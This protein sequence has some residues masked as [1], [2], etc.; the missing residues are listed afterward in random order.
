MALS[1]AAADASPGQKT[2]ATSGVASIIKESALFVARQPR[3]A[4]PAAARAVILSIAEAIDIGDIR[5]RRYGKDAVQRTGNMIARFLS[6]QPDCTGGHSSHDVSAA[7][8]ALEKMIRFEATVSNLRNSL[9]PFLAPS[10]ASAIQSV[11][12]RVTSSVV[13]AVRSGVDAIATAN[14][15]A[16]N[17]TRIATLLA[18][19][20]TGSRN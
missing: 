18:P 16:E 5:S 14:A 11:V 10:V 17:A 7:G 6:G 13:E 15:Y 1:A 2:T 20:Y 9:S 12:V 19:V 3:D 4:A 8:D